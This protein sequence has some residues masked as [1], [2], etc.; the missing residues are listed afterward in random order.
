MKKIIIAN[1]ILLISL[2]LTNCA[3]IVSGSKQKVSF[4]SSPAKATVYVNDVQL[5][6]T[7]FETKLKRAVKL[8]KV[9]MVLDGYKPYETTL[10]RKFNGWY[11]GNIAFGGLIGIIVDLSTG[12]VYRISDSEVNVALE[13]NISMSKND[14]G[15]YFAVVM[16]ADKNWTKIGNLEK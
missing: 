12:A 5:G 16:E 6:V 4:T 7:P 14:D 9:K 15:I 13:N 10:T 2:S 11:V 1:F 3:T 8:H